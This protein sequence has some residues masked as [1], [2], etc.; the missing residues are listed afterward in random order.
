MKTIPKTIALILILILGGVIGNFGKDTG[1][2]ISNYINEDTE[3]A[4]I[5]REL[6]EISNQVNRQLPMMIDEETRCDTTFV[7]GKKIVYKYTMVNLVSDV[8]DTIVFEK[9]LNSKAKSNLCN[10]L[11]TIEMIKFGVEIGR[12]HV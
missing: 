8:F 10:D 11:K 5:E 3:D 6:L 1:K 7:I 9:E 2:R 12:A 4:T